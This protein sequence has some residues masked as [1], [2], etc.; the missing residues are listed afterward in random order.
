M[1]LPCMLRFCWGAPGLAG[2]AR[3]GSQTVVASASPCFVRR[4]N[5]SLRASTRPITHMLVSA[6]GCSLW[7]PLLLNGLGGSG[8]LVDQVRGEGPGAECWCV[9]VML[10]AF[11]VSRVNGG[12]SELMAPRDGCESLDAWALAARGLLLARAV[13]RAREKT[14]AEKGFWAA[15]CATIPAVDC[16]F[17]AGRRLRGC[18]SPSSTR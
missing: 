2:V 13:Q 1:V 16:T 17:V 9:L 7:G 8:H 10:H 5:A 4:L 12:T 14:P 18:D 3:T 6:E 15:A 11:T